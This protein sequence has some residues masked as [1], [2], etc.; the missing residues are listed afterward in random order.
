MKKILASLSG[1][2]YN[3]MPTPCAAASAVPYDHK[4][5]N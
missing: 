3:I 2:C 4:E 1:K 5:V